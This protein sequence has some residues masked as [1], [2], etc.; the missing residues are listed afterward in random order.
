MDPHFR[1]DDGV[2]ELI[3]TTQL[4]FPC[5]RE[6]IHPHAPD[7]TFGNT[8]T[9][10]DKTKAKPTATLAMKRYNQATVLA[11]RWIPAFARMTE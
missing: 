11:I 2:R 5:I 1:E 7:A 9:I 8:F 3:R 6:S 10:T 4:S